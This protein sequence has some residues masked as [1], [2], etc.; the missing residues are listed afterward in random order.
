[1]KQ[2]SGED[3]VEA[4]GLFEDQQRFR[5][6]GKLFMMCNRLP[7]IHA[8]DR[9]T[10]RRI[11]VLLFGS[12]FVDKSDPELKIGRPNVF[13]RDMIWTQNFVFGG[14]RGYLFSSMCMRRSIL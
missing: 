12:K 4:R 6:T 11:R 2:F 14:K 5:I 3:V 10:W 7:P 9:G 1:M 8:M 13:P